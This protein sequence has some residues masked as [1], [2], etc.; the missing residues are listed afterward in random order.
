MLKVA[1]P[2][3]GIFTHI[4]SWTKKIVK[5]SFS[6]RPSCKLISRNIFLVVRLNVWFFQH[7]EDEEEDIL[8]TWKMKEKIKNSVEK[9]EGPCQL[10]FVAEWTT[11]VLVKILAFAS[12]VICT[13]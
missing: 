3:C 6:N 12:S 11:Q 1:V 7:C 2:Q 5:P 9:I 4:L 10:Q 13:H 8:Y